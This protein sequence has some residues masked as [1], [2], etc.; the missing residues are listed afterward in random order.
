M[1]TLK[2]KLQWTW[3]ENAT[4]FSLENAFENIV[5]N[6]LAIYLWLIV[7]SHWGR[8]THLCVGYLTIIASDNGLSPSQCQAIIWTNAAILLIRHLRTNFSEILIEIHIFSFK[9]MHLKMSSVKRRPF[10]VGLIVLTV[11]LLKPQHITIL[12]VNYD[13]SS[14]TVLVWVRSQNCGCLVTWFCY[15]LIANQ[16]TR[17]PK[18]R[19]LTHIILHCPSKGRISTICTISMLRNDEK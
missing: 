2:N 7:L 1:S 14:T 19:V 5:C 4:F 11:L 6:V 17:Q 3:N 18:F 8:V 15:H 16:V 13:I 12:V 10:C 9:K